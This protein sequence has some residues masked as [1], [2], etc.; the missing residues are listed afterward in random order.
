M[1]ECGGGNTALLLTLGGDHRRPRLL[2]P[3]RM[4][5]MHH[6]QVL[7]LLRQARKRTQIVLVVL[8]TLHCQT[9]D[10][11]AQQHEVIAFT[12]KT[13]IHLR[14]FNGL[15]IHYCKR[16]STLAT[17]RRRRVGAHTRSHLNV[18]GRSA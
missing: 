14:R 2:L 9:G 10:G 11:V 13:L 4:M 18:V 17:S 8:K 3:A 12:P 15:S 6:D 7:S 16:G 5:L 1:V